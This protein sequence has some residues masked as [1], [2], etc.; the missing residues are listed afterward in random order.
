MIGSGAERIVCR[1]VR[2]YSKKHR[3]ASKTWSERQSRDLYVKK[4]KEVSFRCRS[5]FK[6]IEIN[7]KYQL[8]KPGQVVI[9]CGCA[10]GS[11]SQVV[12]DKINAGGEGIILLSLFPYCF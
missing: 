10:P 6:L 8:L 3:I 2:W 11:W 9:D 7:E 12:V 4:A 1:S 5:A